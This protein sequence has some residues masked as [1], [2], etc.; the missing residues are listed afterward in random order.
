[1]VFNKF[2]LQP[3][4]TNFHPDNSITSVDFNPTGETVATFDRYGTFLIS[5]IDTD[6]YSFH[7]NLVLKTYEEGIIL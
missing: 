6:N 5:D 4:L 7:L 3:H 2:Q 1:M